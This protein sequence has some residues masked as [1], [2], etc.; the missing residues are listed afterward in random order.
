[1]IARVSLDSVSSSVESGPT[2]QGMK[3][4][5]LLEFN[6]SVLEYLKGERCRQTSWPCGMPAPF[7]NTQQEAEDALPS[8]AAA[9]VTTSWDDREA[10]VFLQLSS[11][12]PCE[13]TAGR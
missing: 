2:Y 7:F 9:R 4:F 13:H 5:A 8:I 11:A 3:Y 12:N 10:I 6:F 1:M